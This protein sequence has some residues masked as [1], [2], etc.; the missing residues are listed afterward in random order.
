MVLDQIGQIA[1]TVDDPEAA[2]Q[3]YGSTLGLRK[4]YRFGDM[5]FFDCAGVR[6]LVEKEQKQPFHPASSVLYFRVKDIAQA[7]RD[8]K[9]KGVAFISEPHLIAPMP[10]HDLWMAFLRN[11]PIQTSYK[12]NARYYPGIF[13]SVSLLLLALERIR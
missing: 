12:K 1:L 3:F 9:A 4:L 7:T 2:E 10:D 8:L 5:L 11:K 6:L 13:I